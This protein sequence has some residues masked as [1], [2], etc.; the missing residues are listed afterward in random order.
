MAPPA[1]P[2]LPVSAPVAQSGLT[3][4]SQTAPVIIA[5]GTSGVGLGASTGVAL[6]AV[7]SDDAQPGSSVTSVAPGGVATGSFSPAATGVGAGFELLT[8]PLKNEKSDR[9]PP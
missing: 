1:V 7:K 8:I 5:A 6:H 3:T 4:D 2:A 9:S